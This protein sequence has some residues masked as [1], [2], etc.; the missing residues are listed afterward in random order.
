MKVNADSTKKAWSTPKLSR[1]QAGGAEGSVPGSTQTN[2]T[3][4]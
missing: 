1:M 2:N 3:R 4:S